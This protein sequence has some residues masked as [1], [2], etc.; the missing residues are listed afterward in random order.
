[1]KKL[2]ATIEV[3][4]T[5]AFII[6]GHLGLSINACLE[7]AEN[8]LEARICEQCSVSYYPHFHIGHYETGFFPIWIVVQEIEISSQVCIDMPYP[9]GNI[10]CALCLCRS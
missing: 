6:F 3:L 9:G 5:W 4:A 8:L 2:S 7:I 10:C 1:M